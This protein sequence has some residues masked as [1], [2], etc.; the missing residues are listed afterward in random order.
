LPFLPHCLGECP[1]AWLVKR[2]LDKEKAA[3][4]LKRNGVTLA[5]ATHTAADGPIGGP[6][7]APEPSVPASGR[8]AEVDFFL[9]INRLEQAPTEEPTAPVITPLQAA[10]AA[11][12]ALEVERPFVVE[13][14][15][16]FQ[17]RA[18]LTP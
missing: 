1:D 11:A 15:W 6:S 12:A 9:L 2:R 16:R 5:A 13:Y 17:N 3:R 14:D 7:T 4:S 10:T 8:N 18:H